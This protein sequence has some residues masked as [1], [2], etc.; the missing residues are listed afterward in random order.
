M[1]EDSCN[2]YT[3][4]EMIHDIKLKDAI[5]RQDIMKAE[6][7]G[8]ILRE[9]ILKAQKQIEKLEKDLK[10]DERLLISQEENIVN[11]T[12]TI[13]SRKKFRK[14]DKA[15]I[16]QSIDRQELLHKHLKQRKEDFLKFLSELRRRVHQLDSLLKENNTNETM[17]KM[18]ELINF[19]ENFLLSCDN[20]VK[21]EENIYEDE[22]RFYEKQFNLY[23]KQ[24]NELDSE[25][26][27]EMKKLYDLETRG[28]LSECDKVIY[29]KNVDIKTEQIAISAAESI[30]AKL[31]MKLSD[32]SAL[33]N[34]ISKIDKQI[35]KHKKRVIQV[36]LTN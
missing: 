27:A 6:R 33:D 21:T 17:A 11:A 2:I 18:R 8:Q 4:R 14:N 24:M 23:E 1:E 30:L 28:S 35:S 25:R 12:I 31:K 13:N 36:D 19:Y 3:L 34:V 7:E 9:S 15:L 10:K 5:T 26:M 16:Q 32:S 22:L 29:S 20:L